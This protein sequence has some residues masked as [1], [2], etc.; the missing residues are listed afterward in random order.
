M[1]PA[2]HARQGTAAQGA[3]SSTQFKKKRLLCFLV[4]VA[5][6]RQQ[7]PG[8][9]RLPRQAHESLTDEHDLFAAIFGHLRACRDTREP[10]TRCFPRGFF[11]P[12][13]VCM[14]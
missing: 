8:P 4:E 11:P 13:F 2:D 6:P 12:L 10:I 5:L 1:T 14:D 3:T 9:V 7:V